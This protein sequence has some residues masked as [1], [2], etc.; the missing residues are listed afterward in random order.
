MKPIPGENHNL[1]KKKKNPARV[2]FSLSSPL[3]L[4]HKAQQKILKINFCQEYFE[5]K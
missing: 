3:K 1:K 4:S 2:T 5:N